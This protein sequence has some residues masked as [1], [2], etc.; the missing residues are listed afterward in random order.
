[1]FP[2][3]SQQPTAVW[4]GT[5]RLPSWPPERRAGPAQAAG[6][7]PRP[8]ARSFDRADYFVGSAFRFEEVEV[9]GFR[10]DLDR[11]GIET[12]E[13]SRQRS[14]IIVARSGSTTSS[15]R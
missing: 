8:R 9:L 2:A 13:E 3:G 15:R 14:P 10:I 5:L 11:H 7:G 12:V 4:T 6:P 1:M